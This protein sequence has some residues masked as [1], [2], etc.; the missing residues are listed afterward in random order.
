MNQ[1]RHRLKRI[2]FIGIG[3]SGMSG[4]AEVLINLGYEVSGS[5]IASSAIIDRLRSKG[6][7]IALDHKESNIYLIDM[8]VLSS[9]ISEENIEL[10]AAK[11]RSIPILARAEMLSSLMNMKRGIAIAGTHGKTT[12]T[13]LLASIF[14]EAGLDPT[15][16]NGGVVNSFASNAKL[17]NGK[18]LIA[19]AD[20]S[21]KSFLMLQPSMAVIT[22]IEADHLINYN[23]DFNNLKNAF[24]QFVKKLPFNGLLVA[25]G[26]DLEIKS[27][28]S[29][30]ARPKVTY[31]FDESNDYVLKDYLANGFKCSFRILNG[32]ESLEIELNLLGKHNALNAAAAAVISLEE[33]V[34]RSAIQR[35]L[36]EFS[37]IDRR[38]QVRGEIFINNSTLTLID[39]YGHHPTEI[40]STIQSIR[41]SHPS[42]KLTM[43]FQP[44]RYTRTKD[45]FNEFIE[46]LSTV[47]K[48]ILLNV[49]PAGEE[50]IKGFTSKDIFNQLSTL[51]ISSSLALN[52]NEVLD[53]LMNCT[54]EDRGLLLMQ[55]AGDISNISNLV[56]KKLRK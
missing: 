50:E 2:H 44:H 26:D 21:D 45:L 20:E 29:V 24:L 36:K 32:E 47:D 42:S 14:T 19:E 33:G 54:P 15:F 41:D 12:T 22:N 16:I 9:A 35:A 40:N 8:V 34:E 43:V 39:D 7:K 56:F 4:I 38:M 1:S 10:K 5:D 31:G 49:Y 37:G 6:A 46:V 28:L 30:F 51:Q 27:M 13:S 3:G 23:N 11:E 17:G 55:G 48:L 25:C 53:S 52:D 18:Y